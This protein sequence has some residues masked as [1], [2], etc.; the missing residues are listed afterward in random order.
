VTLP[1]LRLHSTPPQVAASFN[2]YRCPYDT[3]GVKASAS[4]S[5]IKSAFR[6]LV[7]QFHPDV[8]TDVDSKHAEARFMSIQQAYELLTKKGDGG[9]PRADGDWAFHDWFWSFTQKRR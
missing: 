3:L 5:E 2:P 7:L 4:D 9:R 8:T 6:R 1:L